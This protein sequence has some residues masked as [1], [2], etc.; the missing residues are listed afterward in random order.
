[1]EKLIPLLDK[2]IL[3][4]TSKQINMSIYNLTK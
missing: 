3:K 4:I 1:M 2:N